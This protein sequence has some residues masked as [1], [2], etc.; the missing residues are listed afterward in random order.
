MKRLALFVVSLSIVLLSLSPAFAADT[1]KSMGMAGANVAIADDLSAPYVNPAGIVRL[2]SK[3]IGMSVGMSSLSWKDGVDIT[4]SDTNI[5]ENLGGVIALGQ[6]GM[7]DLPGTIYAGSGT[8]RNF[9]LAIDDFDLSYNFKMYTPGVAYAMKVLPDLTLG[10]GLVMLYEA[11]ESKVDNYKVS[12]TG[13]GIG[14][15]FGALYTLNPAMIGLPSNMPIDLGASIFLPGSLAITSKDKDTGYSE[16]YTEASMNP[17]SASIG[18]AMKPMK[19]LTVDLQFDVKRGFNFD[20]K[21]IDFDGADYSYNVKGATIIQT[22]IGAEYLLPVEGG[23]VPLWAGL[24][25]SPSNNLEFESAGESWDG[26]SMKFMIPNTTTIALGGGY[27]TDVFDVGAAIQLISGSFKEQ[28]GGDSMSIS[29][30]RMI[31]S[32]TYKL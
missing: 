21:V 17:Y 4:G 13:T 10:A 16:K 6:L 1:A 28:Q 29:E 31:L 2:P 3:T 9:F 23:T 15:S 25:G 32:G 30:T 14:T 19:E 20:R 5:L 7:G 11:D 8:A 26:Q 24:A 18:G 12:S 22:R 27:R